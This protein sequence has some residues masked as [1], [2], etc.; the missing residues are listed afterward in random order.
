MDIIDTGIST[1]IEDFESS[2]IKDP[3]E[4]VLPQLS[5]KGFVTHI[6][7]KLK[8]LLEYTLAQSIDTVFYL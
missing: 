3:N 1:Y 8:Q 6:K 2:D 4:E 5:L 7:H